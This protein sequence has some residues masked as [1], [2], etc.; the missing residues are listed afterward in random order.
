MSCVTSVTD[1]DIAKDARIPVPEGQL[2]QSSTHAVGHTVGQFVDCV[3]PD[4]ELG[5]TL[6][7][8]VFFEFT[9]KEPFDNRMHGF[10]H[11]ASAPLRGLLRH[12]PVSGSGIGFVNVG[13]SP[14]FG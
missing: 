14:R 10:T 6:H 11:L 7:W 4:V 8:A 12:V 3:P 13:H 9:A 1:L 5:N 2:S